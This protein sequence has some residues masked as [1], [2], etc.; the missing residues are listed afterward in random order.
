M[1]ADVQYRLSKLHLSSPHLH[2]NAYIFHNTFEWLHELHG[3]VVWH[4]G[5]VMPSIKKLPIWMLDTVST[6]VTTLV[7]H[8]IAHVVINFSKYLMASTYKET[9]SITDIQEIYSIK[10]ITVSNKNK[11]IQNIMYFT[12]LSCKRS[13]KQCF[14][15]EFNHTCT[16]WTSR[17]WCLPTN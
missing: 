16:N 3:R 13:S 6:C 9:T 11:N 17:T 4:S 14:V 5:A 12:L 10:K 7:I 1:C 2:L 15:T 8:V